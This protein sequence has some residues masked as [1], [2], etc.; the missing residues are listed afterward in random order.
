MILTYHARSGALD[1]W[2]RGIAAPPNPSTPPPVRPTGAGYY[3]VEN[4]GGDINAA[5]TAVAAAGGG[6]VTLPAG[7]FSATGFAQNGNSAGFFLP[8]GVSLAGSGV[9]QTFLQVAPDTMTTTQANTIPTAPGTTN[10]LHVLWVH[11]GNTSPA[12]VSQLTVTGTPQNGNLYNGVRISRLVNPT[13][14]DVK[15]VGIPGNNNSPPG[16]TF[17]V[18]VFSSPGATLT[19][20]EVD[21]RSP[22]TGLKVGAAGIGLNS[23]DNVTLTDCHSHHSGYSHG[24]AGWQSDNVTSSNF[25]SHD[26]GGGTGTVTGGSNQAAG[27]NHERCS[28]SVHHSPT[29]G[30]NTLAEVRYWSDQ[31]DTTGHALDHVTITDGGS[32]DIKIANQQTSHPA[33]T[34]SPT[35][36]YI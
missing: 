16:E 33:L 23:S 3:P 8:Q 15:V 1:R 13:V 27:L 26:N 6:T 36:R 12:S 24:F 31:G 5:A 29:L 7:T 20:V 21:G 25:W 35:P 34:S 30:G 18:N 17:G 14:T 22:T 19:R 4:Y 11:G 28:T 32:F 2:S 10:Q 9:D